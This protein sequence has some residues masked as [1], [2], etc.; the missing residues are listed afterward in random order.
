MKSHELGLNRGINFLK[1]LWNSN[2]LLKY[3][4]TFGMTMQMEK[5][6]P[7]K[8]GCRKWSMF[9]KKNTRELPPSRRL[10]QIRLYLNPQNPSPGAL[11]LKRC[12]KRYSQGAWWG[13]EWGSPVGVRPPVAPHTRVPGRGTAPPD[14]Q[15]RGAEEII[16]RGEYPC[17][18]NE[19]DLAIKI[20]IRIEQICRSKGF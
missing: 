7:L 20:G 18:I 10:E 14:S 4:R 2:F 9:L 16:R 3:P 8:K 13:K 15:K 12:P 1:F 11:R 6:R 19:R 17:G 5:N